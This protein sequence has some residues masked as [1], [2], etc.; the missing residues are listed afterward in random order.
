MFVTSPSSF[1]RVTL[2]SKKSKIVLTVFS[3]GFCSCTN[4]AP[5]MPDET[6]GS[7]LQA[8]KCSEC[9]AKIAPDALRPASPIICEYCGAINVRQAPP[10][11]QLTGR[12]FARRPGM[13]AR[14]GPGK[15][16]VLY[17]TR[18]LTDKGAI[19]AQMLRKYTKRNIDRRMRPA[20]ALRQALRQM[21]DE[22]K[23]NRDK[24]LRAVDELIA[25]QKLPPQARDTFAR[26]LQ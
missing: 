23:L 10:P 26:L 4:K 19:D 15:A 2:V 5:V 3:K 11:G 6:I 14:R 1:G 8:L 24:I 20:V 9:G 25:D 18:L 7:P 17:A 22:G 16:P 12:R 21:R 13:A